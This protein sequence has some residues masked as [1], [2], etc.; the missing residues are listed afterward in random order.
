MVMDL[1]EAIKKS[2]KF[3]KGEPLSKFKLVYDAPTAQLEPIYFWLLDFMQESGWQVEKI[4]DNFV[5]SPGSG[6]FSEMGQK[7]TKMQEEGMKILGGI[8]QVVKSVLNLLYDLKEFEIRIKHYEDSRDKDKEKA[9]SAML[10]LKQIWLD[11]VDMKRG[12]GSIHQ[13]TYELGYTTL[14]DAFMVADSVKKIEEMAREK[15]GVINDQVKRILI[16]RMAEFMNWR[17]LSEKELK[18]RFEI[19]KSYLRSQVETLKLYTAWA[20]PYLKASEELKQTGFESKDYLVNPKNPALVN[21]FNTA[22]FELVLFGKRKVDPKKLAASQ[23]IPKSFG[24]YK[25]KREY[26]E[27]NVVSF[28]FR[29]IP[30]KVTPQN[31]GFGGRVEVVF[32]SYI[33][34]SEEIALLKKTLEADD[35][36]SSFKFVYKETDESFKQLHEDISHFLEEN[37]KKV[38]EKKKEDETNPFAVIWSIFST[39]KDEKKTKDKK[40]EIKDIKDVKKDDYVEEY[41]RKIGSKSSSDALYTLYDVYKKAHGHPSSPEPFNY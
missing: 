1:K 34:N 22:M 29:G 13:M 14:R 16:P 27:I 4:T 21:M 23:K 32:N 17:E 2:T 41:I 28:T 15:E 37:K 25:S 11:N 19:E 12:R 31:Y 38:E 30:Q 18:K 7:L 20:R 9:S 40:K 39:N 3:K 8:N 33:L 36:E 5:A 35:I 6:H 24:N 10:A 26:F